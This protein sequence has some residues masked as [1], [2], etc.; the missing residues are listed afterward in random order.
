MPT[1]IFSPNRNWWAKMGNL[2]VQWLKISNLPTLQLLKRSLSIISP[3]RE[4]VVGLRLRF[5]QPTL[6]R[7]ESSAL[8]LAGFSV[9]QQ[10]WCDRESYPNQIKL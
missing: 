10:W 1:T 7:I 8:H 6:W 2:S 9:I 4:L 5:T 3:R